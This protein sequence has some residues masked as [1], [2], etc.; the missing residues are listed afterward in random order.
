MLG[1]AT[2]YGRVGN[3]GVE[4]NKQTVTLSE[5]ALKSTN[6]TVCQTQGRVGLKHGILS[7]V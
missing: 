1:P 2:G 3:L 7:S 5:K 6:F 4:I